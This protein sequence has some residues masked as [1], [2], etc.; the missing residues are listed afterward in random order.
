MVNS[1]LLVTD[2]LLVNSQLLV[3][4][5]LLANSQLLVTDLLLVNSQLVV[6]GSLLFCYLWVYFLFSFYATY[7]VVLPSDIVCLISC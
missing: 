1:Q 3:T 6:R 7:Y 2:L 5:L 4:D